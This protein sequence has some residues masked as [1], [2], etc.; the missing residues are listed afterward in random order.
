[1][2]FLDRA[3]VYVRSGDGGNGCVSFRR[4]KFI[5]FG[6][7]NG[8]DGG[9][10]GS[11][12][13]ESVSG[14]TT[15][16]NYRYRRH[17][18]AKAGEHGK[19]KERSGRKGIDVVLEVPVGT[20]IL[21]EDAQTVIFDMVVPDQRFLLLEGGNGGFGNARFKTSIN[22]SPRRANLGLAGKGMFV[23]LS[24]KLISDVGLIGLPN[25]GK[26]AFISCVTSA[27]SKVADYAFTTLRPVLGVVRLGYNE[28]VLADLP[29][30]S[31]GS[32]MNRGLG[33]SFL[34]HVERCRVLLHL[35]DG[36]APNIVEN[37]H[38]IRRE[39]ELYSSDL[40]K[41]SEIVVISKADLLTDEIKRASLVALSNV[42]NQRPLV[43]S[44]I[45]GESIN[46]LLSELFRALEVEACIGDGYEVKQNAKG[47]VTRGKNAPSWQPA[48]Y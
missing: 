5:E 35:V 26:S 37:Y 4:E 7:P 11:V 10:G 23:Y 38:T 27:R 33:H 19:G 21:A 1:M 16:G 28:F 41:K 20:E 17:F 14:L 45:S 39:L 47:A 13:V 12:W 42:T 2:N 3:K 9:R 46:C 18:K 32:H 22:R 6:G 24:L 31:A 30:L 15:L 40:S 48:L 44:S 25:A 8:G 34:S 43:I 36:T 29:G